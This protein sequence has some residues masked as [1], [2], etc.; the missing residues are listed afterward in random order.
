MRTAPFS[1]L[2]VFLSVARHKSF[3][4][5]ARELGVSRSA[6]SQSVRQLEDELRV[7]LVARTTRSVSLTDSGK[8]L[9]E[10]AGPAVAQLRAALVEVS[11]K[12]GEAVG[13]LRLTVPR[14]GFEFVIKPFLPTFRARHPRIELE[15]VFEDRKVDI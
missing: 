6:V 7:T 5:A 2:Q 4:S 14:A 12:P 11:A 9:L 15:L 13:R 8:R 10:S 3:S 1:Q